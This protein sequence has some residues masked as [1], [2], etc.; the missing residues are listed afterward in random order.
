[1][2]SCLKLVFDIPSFRTQLSTTAFPI[3]T[4]QIPQIFQ[5]TRARRLRQCAREDSFGKLQALEQLCIVGGGNWEPERPTFYREWSIEHTAIRKYLGP[6]KDLKALALFGGI[7]LVMNMGQ[8]MMGWGFG[9]GKGEKKGGG[10][11]E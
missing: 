6:H 8:N 9:I 2:I 3:S 11:W 4:A 5:D 7:G 10:K 1:M